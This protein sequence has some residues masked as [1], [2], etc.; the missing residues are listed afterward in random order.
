[1]RGGCLTEAVLEGG[2][3]RGEAR[4]RRV[5]HR[6]RLWDGHCNFTADSSGC[7]AQQLVL[8]TQSQGRGRRRRMTSVTLPGAMFMA[9]INTLGPFEL[10]APLT[11]VM[12]SIVNC[13]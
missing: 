2:E 5:H 3:E 8:L 7:C 10:S 4:M 11:V 13:L 6:R 12:M 1:M 9:S